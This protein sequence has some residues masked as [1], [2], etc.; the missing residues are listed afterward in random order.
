[1]QNILYMKFGHGS[2]FFSTSEAFGTV[3][4]VLSVHSDFVVVC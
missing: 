3:D 2:F 1:M 4:L